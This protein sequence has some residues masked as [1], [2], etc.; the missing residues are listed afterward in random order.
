MDAFLSENLESMTRTNNNILLPPHSKL[1]LHNPDDVPTPILSNVEEVAPYLSD[2]RNIVFMTSPSVSGS[3]ISS[4]QD[5]NSTW[6]T[7]GRLQELKLSQFLNSKYFARHP[8]EVWR[9]HFELKRVVFSGRPS[10]AHAAIADF[11]FFCNENNKDLSIVA[12]SVDGYHAQAY[13]EFLKNNKDLVKNSKTCTVTSKINS[14]MEKQTYSYGIFEVNGNI[15]SRRCTNNCHKGTLPAADDKLQKELLP[16][17]PRCGSN[18][19]PH[20]L[21]FDETYNSCDYKI[22]ELKKRIDNMDCLVLVDCKLESNIELRIVQQALLSGIPII[23]ISAQPIIEWGNV[24]QIQGQSQE[25][26]PKLLELAKS[27][28]TSQEVRSCM[29]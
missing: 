13:N 12:L 2:K 17:C 20:H 6:H 7:T 23:E 19:R 29:D 9:W 3:Y 1:S 24:L 11:Q 25:I 4:L 21:C 15:F 8:E 18:A 27:Q 14:G 16:K 5:Y 28:C 26:I 22:P 10:L